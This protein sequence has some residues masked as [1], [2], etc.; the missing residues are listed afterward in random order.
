M[1]EKQITHPVGLIPSWANNDNMNDPGKDWHDTPSKVE[2]GAGKRDAGYTGEEAPTA[3]HLNHQMNEVGK[4]IQ[5]LSSVQ[6]M[7]WFDIG[8]LPG[9]C[10]AEA[11]TYDEGITSWIF[12][13]RAN[14]FVN[15]RDSATFSAAFSSPVGQTWTAAISKRPDHEPAHTG[16]RSLFCSAADA[17]TNEIVEFSGSFTSEPLP[18]TG[19]KSAVCMAWDVINELWLI[20][21]SEDTGG[22]PAACFWYD[23][24]P[25]SGPA[26]YVP[27]A[28]NSDGVVDICHG[29]DTNEACLNVAVGSGTSFD[30]FTST[31][32]E[33]W[34]AATPTGIV[35]GEA[36]RAIMWDDKRLVFVLLTTK[37]CYTSTNGVAWSDVSGSVGGEFKARCLTYD[38][39]GLYLAANNT[40]EPLGI[41]YSNDG[42]F[43]WR[44]VVVPPSE[45]GSLDPIHSIAYSRVA[46]RFGAVWVDQSTS[47][48][49]AAGNFTVSLAVGETLFE[50]DSFTNPTVT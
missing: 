34:S 11:L 15:S 44:V 5:Y 12:A 28:I 13:G 20:A 48:P 14:T 16:A 40:A 25:I 41:R 2:P 46:G 29:R 6:V 18:G 36:A 33:V 21:G 30:V 42:G 3:Q 47:P 32:G 49:S 24:T 22:T 37:R 1:A 38:G 26:Q 50:V 27:T 39:G 23:S 43:T 31:D 35:S 45:N 9:A 7:N 17:T 10:T 19:L 4:W 8:E